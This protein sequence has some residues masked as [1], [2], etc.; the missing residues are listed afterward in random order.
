MLETTLIVLLIIALLGPLPNW[1]RRRQWI[2]APIGVAGLVLA[3]VT[4]R[5]VMGRS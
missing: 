4:V 1:S 5:F 2:Q 3:I